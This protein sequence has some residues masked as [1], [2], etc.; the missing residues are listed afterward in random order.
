[1]TTIDGLT[2]A[3]RAYLERQDRREERERRRGRPRPVNCRSCGG[4]KSRPSSVC[5]RCG[6]D[7]VGN[8]SGELG[9]TTIDRLVFDEAVYGERVLA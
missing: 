1:M 4:F 9:A 8:V 5:S 7:P 6:H 3:Q 2:H